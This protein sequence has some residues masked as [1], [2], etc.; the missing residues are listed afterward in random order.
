[1]AQDGGRNWASR[2]RSAVRLGLALLHDLSAAPHAGVSASIPEIVEVPS[3]Y[4]AAR[5]FAVDG[6]RV[7][8]TRSPS[9]GFVVKSIT[10]QTD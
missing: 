5:A 7:I 9:R 1:V 3:F 8:T 10:G 4:R 2:P 6:R